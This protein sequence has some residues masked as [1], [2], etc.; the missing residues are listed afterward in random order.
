M[1]R[2]LVLW[3]CLLLALSM[4]SGCDY[5]QFLRDK[6]SPE[7]QSE[8]HAEDPST[9][10]VE[11]STESPDGEEPLSDTELESYNKALALLAEGNIEDAYDVFL[12]IKD[13]RDVP[14]YLNC[15]S[16]QYD[17]VIKRSPRSMTTYYFEYDEYGRMTLEVYDTYSYLY[18]YDDKGN[19][20]TYTYRTKNKDWVTQYEYDENNFLIRQISPFGV[21]ELEYDTNG[22]IVKRIDYDG[23]ITEYTY[24]SCGRMLSDISENYAVTYQY[25]AQGNCIKETI[26]YDSGS[27]VTT[28]QYDEKGNLIRFQRDYSGGRSNCSEYEYDENGYK[29]KETNY[30]SY[31][32]SSSGST[33][34]T[35][36]YD[37]NG[38]QTEYRVADEDGDDYLYL[39]EYDING[40]LVK[41]NYTSA[42][43]KV[44][45]VTTYEYDSYGNLLKVIQPGETDSPD[46]YYIETY[47]GYK[48]YYN[49][50]PTR[51]LPYEFIGK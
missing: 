22:N 30:Y 13:Y 40:N 35:W 21:V 19:L 15:F 31:G 25:D 3:L 5:V 42:R 11:G 28:R 37:E 1:K 6:V 50:H 27:T 47:L 12:S 39:Y 44:T 7:G 20:I 29:I 33:Y 17:A 46:D 51:E 9:S 18:E 41:K 10:P 48:L 23:G 32:G 26:T 14:S 38:N 4:L 49:P 2:N 8:S 43:S 16:F 24:D 36:K 45:N 34:Y